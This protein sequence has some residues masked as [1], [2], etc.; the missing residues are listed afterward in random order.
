MLHKAEHP[1][2]PSVKA[3]ALKCNEGAEQVKTQELLSR[4]SCIL[5]MLTPWMLQALAR[6][7]IE[8]AIDTEERLKAVTD[9]IFEKAISDPRYSGVCVTM[10]QCLMDLN[11]S[12]PDKPGIFV[13]FR[14]LL[15]DQCQ[16][17]IE[18]VLHKNEFFEKKKEL[19][20]SINEDERAHLKVELEDARNK[21]RQRSLGSLWFIGELFNVQILAAKVIHNC[22]CE[23]LKNQDEVSLEC[24]CKLLSVTGKTLDVD[25]DKPQL[26]SYFA[27]MYNIV[28]ERKTSARIR[29]MLEDV[30]D[31]KG[32]NWMPN[33]IDQIHKEAEMEE[34]RVYNDSGYRKNKGCRK[35]KTPLPSQSK[36]SLNAGPVENKSK[37]IIEEYLRIKDV[38]AAA[39]R[40]SELNT[41]SLLYVFVQKAVRMTLYRSTVAREQM[42]LLLHHLLKEKTLTSQQYY[43]GLEETVK[44]AE[45]VAKDKPLFWRNLAEIITPMLHEVGIAVAQLFGEISKPCVPHRQVMLLV[46]IIYLLCYE[47]TPQKVSAIWTEAGL[48]WTEFLPKGQ[49]VIK[50]VSDKEMLDELQLM[51]PSA[52]CQWVEA[53]EQLLEASEQVVGASEQVVEASEQLL[54]ASEQVVEASEQ[55]VEASGQLLEASEQVVEASEQVEHVREL[56]MNIT[57]SQLWWNVECGLVTGEGPVC[58]QSTAEVPLSKAPSPLTALGAP[59]TAAPSPYS[60]SVC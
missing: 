51:P 3:S 54:E 10:C 29:F 59:T 15:H 40:V 49:D 57:T 42:G 23:L 31:F 32:C 7:V 45:G 6:Q 5:N 50:V 21:V 34:N 58:L 36:S 12:N 44:A 25:S 14:T 8:L 28:T 38:N 39:E 55:V 24:L 19:E 53:S 48:N 30:L 26:D 43:K 37:A 13:E 47:I 1:W 18:K 35:S 9:L 41:P 60:L 56:P 52:E 22:V 16:K 33:R 17:E 27:Q 4:L 20:A 2:K 11:V 46:E